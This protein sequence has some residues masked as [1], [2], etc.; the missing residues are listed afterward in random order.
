M[1]KRKFTIAGAIIAACSV[2]AG[3]ASAASAAPA[4][5][6]LTGSGGAIAQGPWTVTNAYPNQTLTCS[7]NFQLA[8]IANTGS[9]A[10][11]S[12]IPLISLRTC[13]GWGIELIAQPF[14]ASS[15]VG[16][17]SLSSGRMIVRLGGSAVSSGAPVAIQ[18]PW[19]NGLGGAQ[20]SFTFNNT[21][22]AY[23]SINGLPIKLTG[24][25]NAMHSGG[26]LSLS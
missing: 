12:F 1:L 13:S 25:F 2:L 22:I 15:N 10:Q 26:V 3:G 18:V 6:N 17:Y 16:A 7:G 21:T 23:S 14:T 4:T 24:T 8:S 20:S 5:F 19:T 9:P 11:G